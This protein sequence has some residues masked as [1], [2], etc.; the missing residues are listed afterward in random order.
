MSIKNKVIHFFIC[1]ILLQI[2]CFAKP[3]VVCSTTIIYDI[4]KNIIGQNADIECIMPIGGDPHTYEPIPSDASKIAEANI[5]FKN[6]LF[7]EGWLEKFLQNSSSFVTIIDLST[8]ITPISNIQLH[9][10]PDPHIWMDPRNGK[11][12]AQNICQTLQ[13]FDTLNRKIYQKN[14]L[15][16]A[17]KI[18][19]L[20]QEIEKKIK[21][22]P[23]KK[24]IL[25]TTH[26]AFRYYGNAFGLKV[27]SAMGISTD[28]EVLL[29]DM[30]RLTKMI[31]ENEIA[32]IFVESTINPKFFEQLAQDNNI[33][34]GG[35]LYADSIGDST[36]TG[37]T[38]LKMLEANT[39]V[40]VNG[41]Q[42]SEALKSKSS[43]IIPLIL[44]ALFLFL[45]AFLWIYFKI[46]NHHHSN[47][48]WDNYTI[49]VENITV[50]YEK[51]TVLSN[52][53]FTIHSGKLYGLIGPN[54]AGKSTL[55]KS[56]L[57]LVTP[58]TGN[59]KINNSNISDIRNK[60][61]Y[62]PQKEEIDWTFPATVFDIVLTGRLPDKKRF[63]S[64][65]ALDKQKTK[66]AIVKMGLSEFSNRQIGDL[67][68][69]QQQRVFIARAL[70]QEAELLFFD[71]PFVGVD[72][73][74][75][76]KIMS[77]IK[78]LVEEKKTVIMIHHDL[79]K[80]KEY[81]DDI[82]MVNQRLIAHG[83]TTEVFVEGNITKTYGGRLAILQETDKYMY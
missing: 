80:V 33:K 60:I 58:D 29:E 31:H 44:A 30:N 57:G 75:E 16:Y 32:A 6:G 11:I 66:Q 7:L 79:S 69:G 14:Y 77:I 81:F 71:E 56:I 53:N 20:F 28:A 65:T 17:Q 52:I 54:G 23:L 38:Y 74:T 50:S 46:K 45:W 48:A 3:K 63:E 9:G 27:E 36:S 64:Y 82:I 40:I 21:S 59:I 34:I 51:K 5:I 25:I 41:L 78:K 22:I 73:I 47:L 15:L 49:Q 24:R 12:M 37:A 62:I 4:A 76:Q 43:Q 68:G 42:F 70:C 61:A 18:D 67:S 72:V 83:K 1:A 39:N 35:N 13:K 55:F 8:G 19:N 2:S 10:S 26:D